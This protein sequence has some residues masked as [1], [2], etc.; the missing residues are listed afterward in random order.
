MKDKKIII[1]GA[2]G[3]AKVVK[4]LAVLEGYEIVGFL[5]DCKNGYFCDSRILGKIDCCKDYCNE[6]EF[7]IAIGDNKKREEISK[8][9]RLNYA[10]LIHPSA[11]IAHDCTIGKGTVVMAGAVVNADSNIGCHCIVNTNSTIEHDCRLE[12]FVQVSYGAVLSG[13]VC[14]K[15]G[16][17]I[18]ARAVVDRGLLIDKDVEVGQVVLKNCRR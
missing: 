16:L 10:K 1:I 13:G 3:H 9:Y 14:V 8:N 4:D 11:I 7:I 12:D 6:C 2:G 15:R 18:G 5:D 17:N